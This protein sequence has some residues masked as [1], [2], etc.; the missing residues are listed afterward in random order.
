MSI[1]TAGA[2]QAIEKAVDL[3]KVTSMLDV[4][5]GDATM[6]SDF[7][8]NHPNLNITVF[9]LPNSAYLARNRI[10]QEGLTDRIDIVTGDFLSEEPLPENFELVLWSRVLTDW[11]VEVVQKL[12]KKTYDSL[13]PGGRIVICEPLLDDNQDLVT[14]WEFRYIFSDD[15]GVAVYKSRSTYEQLLADSGF[16]VTGFSEADDESFYSVITATR[17]KSVKEA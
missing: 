8:R 15:F 1:T 2:I 17:D 13:I 12:L 16:K 6:A 10:A 3:S 14:A 5:G 9:N 11:P 4:G 7:S